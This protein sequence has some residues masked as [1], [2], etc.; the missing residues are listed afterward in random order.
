VG[1]GVGGGD[2]PSLLPWEE[3]MVGVVE[4]LLAEPVD[5]AAALL[6]DAPGLAVGADA[7]ASSPSRPPPVLPTGPRASPP[8]APPVFRPRSAPMLAAPRSRRKASDL[9]LREG[10]RCEAGQFDSSAFVPAAAGARNTLPIDGH[11]KPIDLIAIESST[12][13]ERAR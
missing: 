9:L 6:E 8:P 11:A 10:V 7:A 4:A 12:G 3:P 5:V 1:G 13:T 2:E